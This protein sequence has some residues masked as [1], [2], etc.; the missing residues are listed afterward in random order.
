M[1]RNEPIQPDAHTEPPRQLPLAIQRASL[2]IAMALPIY[3]VAHSLLKLE[4]EGLWLPSDWRVPT[5]LLGLALGL[6]VFH[7]VR[8][9]PA[10]ALNSQVKRRT[11]SGSSGRGGSTPQ[12]DPQERERHI[13]YC[14]SL[15]YVIAALA[16]LIAYFFLQ[17]RGMY[18]WPE[19]GKWIA[20]NYSLTDKAKP[21]AERPEGSEDSSGRATVGGTHA[22]FGSGA[23]LDQYQHVDGEQVPAFIDPARARILVPAWPFRPRTLSRYLDHIAMDPANAGQGDPVV[24]VLMR[25]PDRIIDWM[26]GSDG[27]AC[28]FAYS[29]VL[30]FMYLA[31]VWSF[32][33]SIAYSFQPGTALG[34]WAASIL[35][36][37]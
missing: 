15:I 11:I 33:T 19:A 3:L 28:L 16:L 37:R 22:K 6:C 36:R 26:R 5:Q 13:A 27:K 32:S 8:T 29:C 1:S 14:H 7:V 9:R 17:S 2:T 34:E 10:T 20:D 18:S 21:A 31:I 12:Q 30:W 24:Q 4:S 25:E 23:P 35:E